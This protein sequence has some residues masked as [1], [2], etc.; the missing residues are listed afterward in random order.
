M[1]ISWNVTELWLVLSLGY[2]PRSQLDG[3]WYTGWWFGTFFYFPIQLGMSSSQLTFTPSFFRG[4]GIPPTSHILL[5]F[6]W[7]VSWVR[8]LYHG[9]TNC[10][11][12]KLSN[13]VTTWW[14]ERKAGKGKRLDFTTW[15]YDFVSV[16][17]QAILNSSRWIWGDSGIMM[18][19]FFWVV[20][21][22]WGSPRKEA[23]LMVRIWRHF[24]TSWLFQTTQ[25]KT[26]RSGGENQILVDVDQEGLAIGEMLQD[27]WHFFK[28]IFRWQW[29][30]QWIQ[31]CR[32][33]G[34]TYC[35]KTSNICNIVWLVVWNIFLF[36]HILGMS[37]S[38]LTNSIIFQRGRYTTNQ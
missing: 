28:P 13:R 36:F 23:L 22:G 1:E 33:I 4:V 14:F 26:W 30:R 6:C 11:H 37:S 32:H 29:S 16:V 10:C 38:Q 24:W 3:R 2:T 19:R 31:L 9:E 5:L 7:P 34:D 20:H 25:N 18:D 17:K 21:E 12:C 35:R 15:F 27:G 8:D